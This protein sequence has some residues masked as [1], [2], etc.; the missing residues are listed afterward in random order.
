VLTRRLVRVFMTM[1]HDDQDPKLIQWLY[2]SRS[3]G[4]K[5]RYTITTEGKIQWIR[6]DVLYANIWFSMNQFR[7]MMHRLVRE[8]REEL[9]EKLIIVKVNVD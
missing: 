2:R 4:F 3:Y 9:F 7:K 8:A 1:A 5:I 6:D